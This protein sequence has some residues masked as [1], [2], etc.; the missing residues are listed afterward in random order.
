MLDSLLLVGNES[1]REFRLGIGL[2]LPYPMLSAASRMTPPV[3]FQTN[4]A[5]PVPGL[6]D[7]LFHFDRKNLL[8][9]W[10]EPEFSPQGEVDAIQLRCQETEGRSGEV[11]IT[12]QQPI[13]S[14]SLTTCTGR[15]L[16]SLRFDPSAPNLITHHFNA[17]ENFQIRIRL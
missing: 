11:T 12:C 2:N 13:A 10:W 9:T 6:D 1:R 5:D 8:V 4:D 14:S 7:W 3:L 17:Y 15:F 16:R